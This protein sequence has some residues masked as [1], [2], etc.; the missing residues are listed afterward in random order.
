[1]TSRE[2]AR[3]YVLELARMAPDNRRPG[4]LPKWGPADD[5]VVAVVLALVAA[6]LAGGG[7]LLPAAIC[8]AAALTSAA[9]GGR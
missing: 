2:R 6:F 8:G 5:Y 7:A 9:A 1:M 4:D 3:C